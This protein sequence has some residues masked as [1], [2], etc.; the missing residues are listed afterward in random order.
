[1]S[2]V[3]VLLVHNAYQQA[4]G[5]DAVVASEAA[6]LRRFGHEVALLTRHNDDIAAIGRLSL[7]RQTLWSGTTR[8]DFDA[9][10][11]EFAPDIVHVH[12]TFPLISPSVY[13]AAGRRRLPVVQTLHNFRLLC[14][15]AIFL[16]DGHICED[17]LGKLPWR[18]V[19]RRCYRA[20]LAQSAALGGMLVLHRALGTWRGH[21]DR[22]IA[23]NAFCR[24]KFIA[25][26]L[27]ADKFSIKPNFADIAELPGEGA[28]RGGLFVGRLSQEK[29]LQVLVGAM[30]RAPGLNVQVIGA[31]DGADLA[32]Q[33]FGAG[34]L[35]YR[36]LDSILHGMRRASYLVVPSIC[37]ES[38]PRTIVEAFAC[39]LPVIASRL[40]SLIDIVGHERTGLLFEPGNSD[41][42]A[43]K[44]AWADAHPER[45]AEMGRAA[46]A[47]YE[48][49][50][51]AETN[52]QMLME[53][54]RHAIDDHAAAR[55]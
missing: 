21:V 1:M 55:A 33:V 50:Y 2:P 52:Y 43:A 27:P 11:C 31:G 29:G 9:S 18:G 35:G 23:L 36:D 46:R 40:G 30:E 25:G 34:F 19:A 24:D 20:S 28:R 54:Y 22:Y 48:R 26:G 49:H 41:D 32:R 47:E 15:Q 6:M 53:I 5:E 17:C 10:C 8:R 45:M 13:W 37:Y 3:R 4:G 39:G 16:R 51:T 44:M 14:P 38:F 12:N 42:L 7:L